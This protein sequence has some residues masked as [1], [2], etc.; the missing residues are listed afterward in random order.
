MGVHIQLNGSSG[1]FLFGWESLLWCMQNDEPIEV[2]FG[3]LLVSPRNHVL[4]G[5]KVR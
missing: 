3:G 5:A 2:P 4:D 1:C